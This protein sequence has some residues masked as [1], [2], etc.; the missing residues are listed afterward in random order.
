MNE[1]DYVTEYWNIDL[2]H[3]E[4]LYLETDSGWSW[5]AILLVYKI[6]NTYYIND[7]E[8]W[9]PYIV[10]QNEALDSMIEFEQ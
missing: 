2:N 3:A 9:S 4:I 8:D 1:Y 6:D 5:W 10:T 7:T